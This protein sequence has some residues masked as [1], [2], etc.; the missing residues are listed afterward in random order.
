MVKVDDGTVIKVPLSNTHKSLAAPWPDSSN[1]DKFILP[2]DKFN[3]LTA[4][5]SVIGSMSDKV[6][7]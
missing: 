6:C 7:L 2:K 3:S 1:G 4:I 5:N